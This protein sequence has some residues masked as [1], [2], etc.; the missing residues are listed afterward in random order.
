M[1]KPAVEGTLS[2]MRACAHNKIKRVV[3]TASVYSACWPKTRD[4]IMT[5]TEADWTHIGEGETAGLYAKSKTIAERAAWDFVA[6]QDEADRIELVT[7]LPS[8]VVGPTPVTSGFESGTIVKGFMA[9]SEPC[10]RH[11]WYLVDV[12]EVAEAHYK[13]T[14][15]KEAAGERFIVS[16]QSVWLSG[17]LSALKT[18]F[19]NDGIVD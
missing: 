7:I 16:N 1:M 6:A 19:P 13:A 8:L 10:A 12:R 3:L 15:V 5:F 14:V 18:E 2:V 9:N 17:L 11:M 4:N